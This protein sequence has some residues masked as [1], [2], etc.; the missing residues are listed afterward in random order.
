MASVD[1]EQWLDPKDY[2]LYIC[3]GV[4]HEEGHSHMIVAKWDGEEWVNHPQVIPQANVPP[5][6]LHIAAWMDIPDPDSSLLEEQRCKIL[7]YPSG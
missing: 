1:W 4:P 7:N 5:A 6:M 2:G 3:G